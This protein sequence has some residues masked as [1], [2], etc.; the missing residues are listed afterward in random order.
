VKE[1]VGRAPL[2]NCPIKGLT[3]D[4]K[5]GISQRIVRGVVKAGVESECL[6]V[7]YM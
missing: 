5:N 3:V 7:V 2:A 1:G 6:F 4:S